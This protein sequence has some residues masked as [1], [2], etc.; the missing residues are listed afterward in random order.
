MSGPFNVAQR[1][2]VKQVRADGNTVYG[3][4]ISATFVV[5][6]NTGVLRVKVGDL[7]NTFNTSNT[8]LG[9]T[10]LANA[11]VGSITTNTSYSLAKGRVYA[12]TE[13]SIDIFRTR[14]GT[15]FAAGSTLTGAESGAQSTIV[16]VVEKPDTPAYGASA[17]INAPAQAAN[18]TIQRVEVFDSGFGY[19]NSELV[20]LKT[21]GNPYIATGIAQLTRQGIG[22]GYW[23]DTGSFISTDKF[24]QDSDFYQDF[25]YE[26]K[27]TLSLEKYKDIL[28][29][30]VHLAGTKLFGRIDR[31]GLA[32]LEIVSEDVSD[33][34]ALLTVTG[35]NNNQLVRFEEISQYDGATK[36]A[37]G[38]L[39][40]VSVQITV[41]GANNEFV[42]GEQVSR[43]TYFANTSYGIIQSAVSDYSA[44]ST[45]LVLGNVRG[46]FNSSGQLQTNFDRMQMTYNLTSYTGGVGGGSPINFAY[47]EVVYQSN[48]SANV[49]VGNITTVNSTHII[50]K[51]ALKLFVGNIA[52]TL[53][54]GS[55]VYQRANSSSPNTAFGTVG[56]SNSTVLE[57]VD[58]RG[59]FVSGDKIYTTTGNAQVI[60]LGGKSNLFT[61]SNTVIMR[62]GNLSDIGF[63]NNEII[64]QPATGA[65]GTLAL[66]NTTY[67][68]INDV[69]GTFDTINPVVGSTSG[70]QA[71]VS[72]INGPFAIIGATTGANAEIIAVQYNRVL[73]TLTVNSSVG[74]INTLTVAN[75]AGHFT[76]NSVIQAANSS[77][78]ATITSVELQA[79]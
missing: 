44:N 38:Y 67:I 5:G 68:T 35:G 75:V 7:A 48:G 61:K 27:S 72:S 74:A 1:E 73:T 19:T 66:G 50:V 41:N 34:N 3:E 9:L 78:N 65:Q 64:T 17:V 37:N 8:V 18:G 45:T 6:A 52:G 77:T 47:P 13:T 10:S 59:Q 29:D 54:P 32:N 20:S 46:L 57:V 31:V 70:V 12:N 55:N 62:I 42:I 2:T 51:P 4:L 40:N 36:V 39:D 16:S 26:V 11:T 14:F 23:N 21:T 76:Y 58:P 33:R 43:P 22:E 69:S 49:G 56:L 28:K 15:S 24:I 60:A 53:T 71:D 25:S 79:Y 63:T 30:T